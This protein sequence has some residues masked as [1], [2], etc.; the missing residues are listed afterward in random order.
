VFLVFVVPHS[1]VATTRRVVGDHIVVVIIGIAA[2]GILTLILDDPAEMTRQTFAIAGA[3][4]VGMAILLMAFTNTEHPPSAGTALSLVAIGGTAGA[5][6]ST[7]FD[8]VWFIISAAI[9]L[10][11]VRFALR[12]WM[13]NL[14]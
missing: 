5:T 4:S 7:V 6:Y 2:Y 13:V 11:I 3:V 10:A 1:V 8:A 14:L 9:I 12:R